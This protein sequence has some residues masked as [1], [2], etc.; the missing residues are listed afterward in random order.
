[1]AKSEK[2]TFNW[3]DPLLLEQQLTHEERM[4]RDTARAYAQDK[5][6]PRVL[7]MFRHEKTD[8][9]IFREMGALDLLG[10]VIP[11]Q[12]GGASTRASAR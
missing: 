6:M 3:S 5:L 10:I 4:V 7:E 12:Y 2:A 8:P 1:M 9:S 11:E